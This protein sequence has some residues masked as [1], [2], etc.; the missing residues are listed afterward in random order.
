MGNA[1]NHQSQD[2]TSQ[3]LKNWYVE[4]NR[5]TSKPI[6]LQPFPGFT[7]FSD[8]VG[9]DGGVYTWKGVTYK[10]TNT[11]LYSISSNGTQ[12]SIGTV[13]GSS[14][15]SWAAIFDEL[16]MCRDGYVYSYDGATLT[17]STDV[18]FETPEFVDLINQ[19]ALYDGDSNR[20]AIS[21]A[22]DLISINGLNYATAETKPG[23]LQRVY[24]FNEIIYVF[25]DQYS[26]QWWNSGAGNPPVDKITNA[27]TLVGLKE[28][29]TICNNK[30]YMYWLGSDC[31]FYRTLTGQA[32]V[33]STIP[34]STEFRGYDSTGAIANTFQMRGQE[35]VV[36]YFPRESK[37][38]LFAEAGGWSELTYKL[39]EEG[40]PFTSYTE[41]YS[42]KLFSIGGSL[43]ELD[44]DIYRGNGEK[45]IRERTSDKITSAIF[46]EQHVGKSV[47][48]NKISVTAEIVG[49]LDQE[50][51]L[52]LG[53]SDDG[54]RNFT[55]INIEGGQLGQYIW[56]FEMYDLGSS[57]DR[58]Y[59]LRV[60]DNVKCSIQGGSME[61]DLG[62]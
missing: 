52:I 41:N 4:I 46:G 33:V 57:I 49:L 27:T 1:Y 30:I 9:S 55:Y 12:T 47:E 28:P 42:R 60:S 24:V 38:W 5:D 16:V 26:T 10:I 54:G 34:I 15:A 45:M 19:Q 31:A 59:R 23:I 43:Y 35:F 29:R 11:T 37:T 50:P 39:T 40:I 22:G 7:K 51:Y 2:L 6:S 32:E 13:L 17:Q 25:T 3:T 20:F 21:D 48:H 14:V 56:L 36:I 44:D 18:D 62:V 61:V 8:G 58:R 53:F